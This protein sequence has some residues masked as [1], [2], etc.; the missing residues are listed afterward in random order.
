MESG[1]EARGPGD[2]YQR[3]ALRPDMPVPPLAGTQDTSLSCLGNHGKYVT[4]Q[5]FR[6]ATWLGSA[7]SAE[8]L[9]NPAFTVD[10]GT[11]PSRKRTP[12]SNN[13]HHGPIRPLQSIE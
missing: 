12:R 8:R 4:T 6:T 2:G 3:G 13:D 10:Q 7:L 9:A 1:G 5:D 11:S